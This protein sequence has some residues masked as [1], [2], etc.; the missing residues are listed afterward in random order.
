M[1]DLIKTIHD[2]VASCSP[3]REASRIGIAVSGGGDSMALMQAL[4]AV[5]NDSGPRLFVATVD[6]GLRDGSAAEA[7]L[8]AQTARDLGLP[9]DT[10]NWT[11]NA[12]SGNL[13]DR[14]RR[15]RYGLL[16]DWAKA[17]DIP[18]IALGHTAEDQAETV[19]MRLRREAGVNGLSGMASAR[20]EQGITLLR[21]LLSLRRED[22]RHY[23]RQRHVAWVEDPSN[24][25]VRFERIRLRQALDQFEALGLTVSGL[26]QVAQNMARVRG[27]L[28]W[29]TA[30]AA[31]S[32]LT[33]E[34]GAVVVDQCAFRTFPEEIA[35]RLIKGVI[36]WLTGNPYAPR[37]SVM[38]RAVEVTRGTGG[39]TVAGCKIQA[40]KNRAWI[41]REFNAVKQ[42]RCSPCDLWDGRWQLSGPVETGQLIASLGPDG[43][44]QCENWRE[45]GCPAAVFHSTP[46]LWNGDKVVASLCRQMPQGWGWSVSPGQDALYQSFLSH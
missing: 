32:C 6:H 20:S 42:L 24:E 22:L 45:Y 13:Q 12:G 30:Q 35:N 1:S 14:A 7:A 10:L 18:V 11:D 37:R 2:C 44:Q 5:F 25:D 46:A 33:V 21:P 31:H 39:L 3:L 34:A 36:S 23:L 26:A 29:S 9:H 8:V 15:A 27:A 4:A 38:D 16:T 40:S 19:L 41:F 17:R 43:L 28:E